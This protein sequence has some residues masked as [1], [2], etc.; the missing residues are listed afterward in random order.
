VILFVF[1]SRSVSFLCCVLVFG[2]LCLRMFA[3]LFKLSSHSF[4]PRRSR[5]L[6]RSASSTVTAGEFAFVSSFECF[7]FSI[8]ELVSFLYFFRVF[9][10][11]F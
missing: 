11:H 5:A 10:L 7:C 6:D 3:F 2:S 9:T 8:I 4:E 1:V